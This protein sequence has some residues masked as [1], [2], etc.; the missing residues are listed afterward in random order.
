MCFDLKQ[1]VQM[2]EGAFFKRLTGV[3]ARTCESLLE[4]ER[5]VRQAS[6]RSASETLPLRSYAAEVIGE[7]GNVFPVSDGYQDIDQAIDRELAGMK[8]C[9]R[10]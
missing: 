7:H 9:A 4:V 6:G 5:F 3:D 10:D 1:G 2:E 8:G